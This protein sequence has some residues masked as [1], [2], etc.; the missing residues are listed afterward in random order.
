MIKFIKVGFLVSFAIGLLICLPLSAQAQLTLELE[1]ELLARN[2]PSVHL[3]LGN[4][5]QATTNINNPDN[6]LM[7]KPQYVLSYNRSNGTPNW[8]SWQLNR[9]C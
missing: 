1:P 4:P 9:A 2:I 5:S 8:V 6:D 3:L 7:I